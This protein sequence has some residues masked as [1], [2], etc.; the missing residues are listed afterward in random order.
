MLASIEKINKYYNGNHVL[1]DICLTIEN[2]DRLG[3]IGDNGCGKSTL[4]RILT[5]LELPDKNPTDEGGLAISSTTTIG[6]L[7]QNSGLD[8]N[9]S[10]ISEMKGAFW[11]LLEAEAKMFS[12]A[13]KL[14]SCPHEGA[15]YKE[16]LT[17]YDRLSAFFEANEGYLID[18]KIKTVLSGMGFPPDRYDSYEQ[19]IS[20]LS[21]GEK[22]RLALAKLLLEAP[23]LLVLDEPT[24]HLDFQTIVWLE[25]YLQG[26][27]G[28]LLL[29]SHDRYFLDRLCTSVAE[30]EKG[31]L[32]RY[33]GNY[34]A[35][36]VQKAAAVVRQ[37]K[38]YE[39]QQLQIAS[40]QEY[41]DKNRA[42][43]STAKSARSRQ[44]TLDKLERIEAPTTSKKQ[45]KIR[46]E[47]DITPPKEILLVENTPLIV[48]EG[49]NRKELIPEVTLE[50][51]RGEK[52]AV[53][54]GNGTGKSSLLKLL[55]GQIAVKGGRVEWANNVKISYFDQ[56]NARL[57]PRHTVMEEIHS[58]FRRM[59]ELEVRS[60]LGSVRLVGENV[61]KRVDVISGGERAKLC[62]AIMMQEHGNVLILDEPTNHL[63]LST[64]EVLEEALEAFDGTMILVSHDRYLLNRLA[65]RIVE[66]ENGEM[67]YYDCGFEQYLTEKKQG[68]VPPK[69]AEQT[70]E[71]PAVKSDSGYRS[72]EDRRLEA[73]RRARVKELEES[74][75][76]DE[77]ELFRLEE[78]LSTPESFSN[79]ARSREICERIEE[80]KLKIAEETEQW[81][82]NV[83]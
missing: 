30:I 29:V 8:K 27:R 56:E 35:F 54:G 41:V 18:V 50:L 80:I 81:A 19:E 74:I 45:A 77:I 10:I 53:I 38:E 59:S 65:S 62:F 36:V 17:E 58:R 34:S 66:L 47:Y 49:E 15:E 64:K 9:N 6:F 72:R 83:E 33:S 24:N 14:E 76:N 12:L 60:L 78:E 11:K 5:G 28:A 51:R 68:T 25:D 71:T 1:D 61:F 37:A 31:K 32:T 16:A 63:D 57:N 73:E 26:Y 46:F 7:Q 67:K 48:G 20:T 22:T 52:L 75:E 82:A 13:E 2:G 3:L 69:K 4:L 43:A 40:L 23:N 70:E 79:Y 42:R 44:N 39:Q 55:Q 21:G